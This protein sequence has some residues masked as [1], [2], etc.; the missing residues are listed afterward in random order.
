MDVV[1]LEARHLKAVNYVVTL[2]ATCY[3]YREGCMV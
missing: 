1:P 3:V 2:S